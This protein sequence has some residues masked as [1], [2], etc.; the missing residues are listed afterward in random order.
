MKQVLV[1]LNAPAMLLAQ[2]AN[3]IRSPFVDLEC[4]DPPS[5]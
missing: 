4:Q 2:R 5:R 1:N 3:G